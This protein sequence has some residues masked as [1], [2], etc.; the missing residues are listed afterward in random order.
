MTDH[1]SPESN[2]RTEP[3]VRTGSERFN[4]DAARPTGR[5]IY[6]SSLLPTRKHRRFSPWLVTPTLL[7]ALVAI[8]YVLLFAPKP[9][10][11][12]VTTGK[13]IYASDA[14][15]PGISHLWISQADGGSVHPLTSG[16]FSDTS[17]AWTADGNQIAFVSDRSE[18]QNQIYVVDGDGKN[19]SQFTHNPGTKSQ[20]AFAP[21]SNTLIGYL[22][23]GALVVSDVAKGEN[24]P[25]LPSTPQSAHSTSTDPSLQLETPAVVTGFAW[26]SSADSSNPGLAAVLE[27]AGIQTLVVLPDFHSPLIRTQNGQPNG[28]PLAAADSVTP[29]WAPDGSHMAVALL[30]VQGLPGGRKGST[31]A[32]FDTQG[33]AQRSLIRPILDPAIGPQ[34]PVFSPDG[35]QI[36]FEVWQQ[37]DLASRKRLGLFIVPADGSG[38]IRPLAKEDAGLAQFS[39]DGKY[40]Y[41]L[42]QRPGGGHDLWRI[43]PEGTAPAR[44]SDGKANVTAFALSPQAGKE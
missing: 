39:P 20:P 7:I 19:L 10:R 32:Q 41:F 43:S 3:E 25:L 23:G 2:S 9:R 40:I 21:G 24:S 34:N 29:A 42:A 16:T 14:N 15:S 1:P 18:G 22:S 28:P 30:H 27:T 11:A 35:S 44:V 5:P 13:L 4:L 33:I 6:E 17:P 31:L 26:R 12:V 37:P 38:A 8:L 36:V